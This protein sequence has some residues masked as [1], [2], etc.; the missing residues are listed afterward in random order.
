MIVLFKK[1]NLILINLNRNK[2]T[3][4]KRIL[5]EGFGCHELQRQLVIENNN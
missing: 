1:F 3:I 4:E 5:K 2:N